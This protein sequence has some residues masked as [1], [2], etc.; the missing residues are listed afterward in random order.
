MELIKDRRDDVLLVPAARL[1]ED[2]GR[3]NLAVYFGRGYYC[4]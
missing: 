2:S 4:R 1:P 3:V